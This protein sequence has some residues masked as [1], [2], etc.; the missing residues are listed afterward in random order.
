M[1]VLTCKKQ[2]RWIFPEGHDIIETGIT[3][4]LERQK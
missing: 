4:R 3:L 2:T 1:I